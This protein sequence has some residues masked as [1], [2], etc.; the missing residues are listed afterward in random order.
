MGEEEAAE[1]QEEEARGAETEPDP[2]DGGTPR[3]TED[4]GGWL[5]YGEIYDK[6][7]FLVSRSRMERRLNMIETRAS[8]VRQCGAHP[9][10]ETSNIR[11]GNCLDKI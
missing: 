7:Q 6:R 11:S 3:A 1:L 4:T 5:G 2:A 10:S 8:I 9:T